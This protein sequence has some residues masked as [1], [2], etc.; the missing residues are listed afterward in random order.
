MNIASHSSHRYDE[1]EW[2]SK[3]WTMKFPK[4]EKLSPH[5]IHVWCDREDMRWFS[6]ACAI[7]SFRGKY[8]TRQNVH[9]HVC[10]VKI[11]SISQ[12]YF[13]ENRIKIIQKRWAFILYTVLNMLTLTCSSRE[14]MK[15]RS[16]NSEALK[17][18]EDEFEWVIFHTRPCINMIEELPLDRR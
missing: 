5:T 11:S 17:A 4:F 8:A 12:H 15:F 16:H 1:Y 18:N 3:K 9:P 13:D 6:I 2:R 7:H 10:M 14:N